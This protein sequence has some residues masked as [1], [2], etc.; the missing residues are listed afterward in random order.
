MKLGIFHLLGHLGAHNVNFLLRITLL[1]R[2]DCAQKGLEALSCL[3][4]IPGANFFLYLLSMR[5]LF[6][7]LM[8]DAGI[9]FELDSSRQEKIAAYQS[10]VSWP[11]SAG[12]GNLPG[13]DFFKTSVLE[14]AFHKGSRIGLK[15]NT[16]HHFDKVC[17]CFFD[18]AIQ[19]KGVVR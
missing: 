14:P 8:D 13:T 18:E 9:R 16:P 7:Y 11:G 19:L 10:F 2:I 6:G 4:K 3:N 15:S 5:I 1:A 12:Q 17:I